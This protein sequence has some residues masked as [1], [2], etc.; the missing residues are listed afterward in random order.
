[1]K[2]KI[3][4]IGAGGF[5]REVYSIINKAEYEIVGFIDN[6]Y[7]HHSELPA[8]VIG[9]DDI[10]PHLIKKNIAEAVCIAIGNM[11]VRSKLFSLA[12]NAGLKIPAIIHS[13]AII[14]TKKEISDGVIIYPQVVVMDNCKI[15]NGVLL[16]SAVTLG[17][18]VTIGNFSNINPGVNLAGRIEIG[19]HTM[20]GIGTCIRENLSIGD[21]VII[22]AGSVV[23]KNVESDQT[24]FGVPAAPRK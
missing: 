17:H 18:D 19:K 5:G 3:A 6:N 15:G 12:K 14:L 22:G 8:P 21:K 24:V 20:V 10:I 23:V 2:S 13:S 7:D 9:G 11:Q 4:I 1:M 16:N